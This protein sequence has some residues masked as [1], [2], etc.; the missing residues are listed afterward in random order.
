MER[1][2]RLPSSTATDGRC[3]HLPSRVTR[4]TPCHRSTS[5]RS[6]PS[7]STPTPRRPRSPDVGRSRSSSRRRLTAISAATCTDRGRE[8]AQ[9]YRDRKMMAVVFTV[10]C[11][12]T[13]GAAGAERRDRP[14]R[15]RQSG[16]ADRIR[17]RRSA[18]RQAGGQRGPPARP[19]ARR[20]GVKFH[21]STQ[22]FF[23]NDVA[24]YPIYEAIAEHDA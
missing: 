18:P 22:A 4:C 20:E 15:G 5:T 7:T 17:Q 6:S 13:M 16:R 19:R 10:D 12:T 9:Y 1:G 11:T 21:P 23:P 14:G 24:V 8:M 3:R 2:R